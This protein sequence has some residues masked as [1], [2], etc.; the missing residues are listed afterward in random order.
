[1][2][3]I[4]GIAEKGRV[5]MGSDSAGVAE[6]E[7]TVYRAPKAFRTGPYVMGY[8]DSFRMGQ[9][10]QHVFRPPPPPR[11]PEQLERFLVSRWV[12]ALRA[13]LKHAG[14]ATRRDEQESGGVFLLG[15]HG[16]LF[17]VDSDYQVGEP[18]DGYDAVGCG[19]ELARGALFATQGQDPETRISIALR[20]AQHFSAGVRGPFHVVSR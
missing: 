17:F 10:L 8:T 3:A 2:T 4:V 7:M 19:R 6:L 14:Y 15:V 13:Q 18:S 12:D 1:M 9:V 11:K 20:A 5:W 16:R